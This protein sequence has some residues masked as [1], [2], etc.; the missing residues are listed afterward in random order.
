MK[1]EFIQTTSRYRN[2]RASGI[3]VAA[4]IMDVSCFHSFVA[5]LKKAKKDKANV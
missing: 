5:K 2:A 1:P 3:G 4:A